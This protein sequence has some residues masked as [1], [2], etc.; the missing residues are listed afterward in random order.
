MRD[1]SGSESPLHLRIKSIRGV[2][3][4]GHALRLT[5]DSRLIS[6]QTPDALIQA[7]QKSNAFTIEAWVVPANTNLK[8]PARIVTLSRN[9]S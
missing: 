8:G 9:G 6:D 1:Q 3:R 5:G 7:I 4:L 2:Q